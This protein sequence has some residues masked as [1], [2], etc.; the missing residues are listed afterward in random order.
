[1]CIFSVI[2]LNRVVIN[3]SNKYNFL[4][5]K[6]FITIMINML[7]LIL[8]IIIFI[9][10]FEEFRIRTDTKRKGEWLFFDEREKKAE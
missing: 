4:S 1:M 5:E 8:I 3:N 10:F 6:F 2:Y 7:N 9:L